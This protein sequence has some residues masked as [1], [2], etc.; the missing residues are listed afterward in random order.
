[1]VAPAQQP[2]VP[3]SRPFGAGLDPDDVA[4]EVS[5]LGEVSHELRN[6]LTPALVA[7]ELL[8]TYR[9]HLP[10]QAQQVLDLLGRDSA[11]FAQLL[12]EL[13]DLACAKLGRCSTGDS[14]SPASPGE[15]V[16]RWERLCGPERSTIRCRSA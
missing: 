2:A 9:A 7:V 15:R 16:R 4:D 10:P 11:S 14:L 1:M 3:S 12:A 6:R 5:L 13:L 8:A